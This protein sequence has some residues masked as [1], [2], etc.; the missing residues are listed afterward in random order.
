M[1]L[2]Q[3]G[4]A[5]SALLVGIGSLYFF[6]KRAI[7]NHNFA[8][9]TI[10]SFIMAAISLALVLVGYRWFFNATP[11]SDDLMNGIGMIVIGVIVALFLVVSNAAKT[12]V[13]YAITSL[14]IQLLILAALAYLA[15]VFL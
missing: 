13:L 5:V 4:A 1:S 2:I 12:N 10:A 14:L 6:N 9:F 8:F 15:N 11:N 7:N 3:I